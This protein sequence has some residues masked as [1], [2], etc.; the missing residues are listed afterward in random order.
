MKRKS[1][2]LLLLISY[3][4]SVAQT[5]TVLNRYRQY[6]YAQPRPDIKP[7]IAQ[8]DTD[9]QWP[10]I[11]YENKEPAGWKVLEH[12]KRLRELSLAW[13]DP[14]SPYYH[15]TTCYRIIHNALGHW[16][17]KRYQS[18][19]WW[20]NKIGVPQFMRDIIILLQGSLDQ[21]E[22]ALALEVMAQNDEASWRKSTG[23]N[24][25]WCAD[26]AFHYGAFTGDSALMNRSMEMIR[27][28]VQVSTREGVQPDFS[29]HQ[30]QQRL[31]TY[32][33]GRAFLQDNVRLAW[34]TRGTPWAYPPEKLSILT[35]FILQ[36]WQWMARGIYTVPGTLDRS[37]SRPNTLTGADIRP[38]IP[39]LCELDPANKSVYLDVATRQDGTGKSLEGFRY[40]PRSDFSVYHHPRFSFFLKTISDRTLPAESINKENLKGHLLHSGDGYFILNG[41]EYTN[42]MPVWNWEHLPGVTA[43]PGARSISR[44]SFAGSVTD[45]HSGLTVMDY[46]L[47]DVAAKKFWACYDNMMVCLIAEIQGTDSMYT[48]L[49][50][51]RLQGDVWINT[52]QKPLQQGD[53]HLQN[54]RWI[55]HNKLA[56]MP[57]ELSTVNLR[58]REQEGSWQSINASGSPAI[59]KEKVFMPVLQK[60]QGY[61]VAYCDNLRQ[62]RKLAD[63]KRWKVLK[64]TPECQALQW[65]DGTVM[66]AFYEAGSV[67]GLAVDGACLVLMKGDVVCVSNP[68]HE[69]GDVTISIFDKRKTLSL[70]GDGTSVMIQ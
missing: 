16:L 41:Q 65:E 33:Y 38:L 70:P 44:E 49:D 21:E 35:S 43:F 22:Q 42:L 34:E 14:A 54:I 48:T 12:L 25:V 64:N 36:G 18:G 30:H 68:L 58:M 11:E 53:H 13:S 45:G 23:A 29:F 60:T 32:H 52:Q 26:L 7:L 55:Y 59:V 24:L 62:A 1:L 6:L 50:Q 57:L 61:A 5:D 63:K 15:D 20:H 56:Y 37:V 28:E 46:H 2:L 66:A 39:Y 31:Q 4:T 19:N 40:Y 8:Y 9:R 67:G 27:K 17:K 47:G 3:F 69:E 51:C 10:D